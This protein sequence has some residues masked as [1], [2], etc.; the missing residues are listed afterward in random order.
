MRFFASTAAPNKSRGG[1]DRLRSNN[2]LLSELGGNKRDG[3]EFASVAPYSS[4]S[5]AGAKRMAA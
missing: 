1:F 2:A 5:G 3:R 4:I